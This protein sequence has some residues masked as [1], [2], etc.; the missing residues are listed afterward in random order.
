MGGM[1]R[2]GCVHAKDSLKT[3]KDGGFSEWSFPLVRLEVITQHLIEVTRP[4]VTEIL[5][6]P[7]S[8]CHSIHRSQHGAA[9]TAQS[10]KSPQD[11]LFS[12]LNGRSNMQSSSSRKTSK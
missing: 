6:S 2:K 3:A 4:H 10:I 8:H 9:V 12:V 1:K 7:S 11:F 5:S